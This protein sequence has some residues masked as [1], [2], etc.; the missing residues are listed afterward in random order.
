MRKHVFQVSDQH[1]HNPTCTVIEEGY[2][3]EISNLSG[4]KIV[5]NCTIC[6]AKTKVL[7][8]QKIWFSH[9]EAYM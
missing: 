3:L 6:V 9:D 1:E 7:M 8:K 5:L 4:R 2:K